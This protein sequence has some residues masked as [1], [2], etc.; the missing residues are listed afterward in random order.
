MRVVASAGWILALA[1]LCTGCAVTVDGDDRGAVH[2]A[3]AGTDLG[4]TPGRIA[5]GE[6]RGYEH[7]GRID[8][9]LYRVDLD[10]DPIGETFSA[11]TSLD[12]RLLEP[13][14]VF[15]LDLA[16]DVVVEDVAGTISRWRHLGDVLYLVSEE[17]LGPGPAH[18]SIAYRGRMNEVI[19][20]CEP[21]FGG[22]MVGGNRAGSTIV[23]SSNWPNHARRWIPSHD[24]PSDGAAVQLSVTLPDEFRVIAS[25]TLV[26]VAGRPGGRKRWS[27]EEARPMPTHAIHIAAFPWVE[28]DLG[29]VSGVPVRAY[30]YGIDVDTASALSETVRAL[31]WSSAHLG[32]LGW[33]KY[34]MVAA[35]LCG[36]S[37]S[38]PTAVSFDESDL[39][40]PVWARRAAVHEVMR[41]WF[42]SSVRIA[43][44]ND[45]WWP[46]AIAG[47][48]T[49]LYMRDTWGPDAEAMFLEE[50]WERGA[51]VPAQALRPDGDEVVP[52]AVRDE[53]AGSTGVWAMRTL[54][55]AIGDEA[56]WRAVRTLAVDHQGEAIDTAT[57]RAIFE[58]E[59]GRD[60]GW[61]FDD[62]V[63]RD[64]VA[65]LSGTIESW[66]PA[67]QRGTLVVTQHQPEPRGLPL[68][69]EIHDETGATT[70][71]SLT[72]DGATTRT[73]VTLAAPPVRVVIDPD[74]TH[75]V[76]ARC[77]TDP[78]CAPMFV[79]TPHL[80]CA[81]PTW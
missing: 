10:V 24:H 5:D 55:R 8:V 77:A 26:D 44:W 65:E 34:A 81:P 20:V 14:R 18:V 41:H 49:V 63:A 68:D 72:L 64:G 52:D 9:D 16:R 2:V 13:A 56:F 46:D 6:L 3:R 27:Y 43:R 35:P 60:L 51:R 39:T 31:E 48:L 67:T 45:A 30:L 59:A 79:C 78:D 11:Y 25:G 76:R 42:G 19:L 15:A 28:H 4:P 17:P 61:W 58:R 70:R 22:L 1:G 37:R 66:D 80:T 50:A 40:D 54:H 38:E 71:A 12:L 7:V 74:A 57:L 73:P 47:Y 33:S 53:L 32:E 23:H 21:D 29:E 69:V 62:V 36:G 75:F